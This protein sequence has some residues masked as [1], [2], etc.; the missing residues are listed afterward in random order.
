MIK[1]I[2]MWKVRGETADERLAS[3]EFVKTRFEGLVGRI[4]GLLRMEIGLDFSRVD[5]AC[6]MVLYSEFDSVASLEG[7]G[8]HPEHLRVRQELGDVR[9]ARFQVD[10]IPGVA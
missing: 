9:I 5:Y 8:A 7:Y 2:V 1:H 10:Y 6:D 4:P 3:A